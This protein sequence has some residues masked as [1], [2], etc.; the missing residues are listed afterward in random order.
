MADSAAPKTSRSSRTA[1]AQRRPAAV[2]SDTENK[3]ARAATSAQRFA[4]LSDAAHD[5][6]TRELFADD[7]ARAAL[8]AMN[9]DTRQGTLAGFEL[10]DD[11]LTAIG[12]PAA[13]R[14]ATDGVAAAGEAQEESGA[15]VPGATQEGGSVLSGAA[16]EESERLRGAR[17]NAAAAAVPASGERSGTTAAPDE[18]GAVSTAAPPAPPSGAPEL[19]AVLA[20]PS[21]AVAT[22]IRSVATARRQSAARAADGAP[23]VGQHAKRMEAAP[24]AASDDSAREPAARPVDAVAV[25]ARDES[26]LDRTVAGKSLVDKLATDKPAT[27]KPATDKAATDKAATDKAAT[28]KA[29]IDKPATDKPATNKPATATPST[30]APSTPS[31]APGASAARPADIA[32]DPAPVPPNAARRPPDLDRVRAAAFADTVDALYGVIADQRRAAGDH[33][34]R[35]KWLLSTVVA[36]LLITIA[37]GVAQTVLLM[38]LTRDSAAQQQR[39]E[40]M[41]RAQQTTLTTLADAAARPAANTPALAEPA[42]QPA[43]QTPAAAAPKH[44]KAP[45]AHKPKAPAT[46]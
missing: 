31:A 21:A 20:P 5:D 33:S 29:A 36:A 7:P 4:Q 16:Q 24:A 8:D 27:D 23:G 39:I 26:V 1:T 25:A 9:I 11:V 15:A 10:P 28:D 12:V 18:S 34:R 32:R 30:P 46:H 42:A 37:I 2:S 6:G 19:D 3:L 40:D 41:L 13:A 43:R 44:A 35:M 14:A 22:A 17:S 38:R 45:H